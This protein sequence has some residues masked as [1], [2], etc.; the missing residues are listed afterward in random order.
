MPIFTSPH[1]TVFLV[2]SEKGSA[3]TQTKKKKRGGG[4]GRGRWMNVEEKTNN[5]TL[6]FAERTYLCVRARIYQIVEG[7]NC[8]PSFRAIRP[9]WV[10]IDI[11]RGL[12][13]LGGSPTLD[14][15]CA[16]SKQG[17][18][19]LSLLHH[20]QCQGCTPGGCNCAEQVSSCY[21][22]SQEGWHRLRNAKW[23]LE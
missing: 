4:E 12:S 14:R 1:V 22:R 17:F 23:L 20:Q 2:V 5:L 15:P 9:H 8:Q 19:K 6:C 10:K 21:A 3:R 11:D 13:S 18:W 7:A 16:G